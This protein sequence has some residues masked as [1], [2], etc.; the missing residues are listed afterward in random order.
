MFVTVQI[1]EPN[2]RRF[3]VALEL[4]QEGT[5]SF[6]FDGVTFSLS[7]DGLLVVAIQS[8]FWPLENISEQSALSDLR[9]ATSV[10]EYLAGQNP[11]FNAI[12]Q[13]HQHLF[14]LVEY[15]GRGGEMELARLV[16]EKVVWANIP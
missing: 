3:E 11:L 2:G 4:L 10:A 13:S 15:Y 1:L 12:Y 9:R 14:I 8:S 16:D 5:S 7:N 6:T